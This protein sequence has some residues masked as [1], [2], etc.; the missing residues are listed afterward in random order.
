MT[1]KLVVIP[2]DPISAYEDKGTSSWLKDYYNPLSYFDEVF[3]L[4]PLEKQARQAYGL[5]IV[6]ITSN[7]HFKKVIREINPLAIR[8]YGGY[9]ASELAIYNRQKS[10]PIITS[11]HD[12]NPKNIFKCLI[13][14][15]HIICMSNVIKSIMQ[16][17]K[18]TDDRLS[19]LGNRVDFS[20][21]YKIKKDDQKIK[22]IRKSFP[23]GKII[24]HIGR[25]SEQKNLDN[26]INALQF[27]PEDYFLVFIGQGNNRPYKNQVNKI[28]KSKNVFWHEKIEN[29]DLVYWYNMADVFC[30][31][32]RWEGFGLVFIEAAACECK[33]I[34]SNIQPMNEFLT[35]DSCMNFLVN[36]FEDPKEIASAILRACKTSS[37]NR[38]TYN[39]IFEKFSKEMIDKREVEIY[40]SIINQNLSRNDSAEFFFW[41]LNKNL[42][43]LK[44]RLARIYGCK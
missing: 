1:K 20:K 42:Q 34:T 9:W 3:A 24:L 8:A 21:F 17:M 18:I 37:K 16:E 11:V 10:I 5:N 31:P 36:N 4:S 2:S 30:V 7:R 22:D 32:S 6:P 38:N 28:N 15:D 26:L 44:G 41:K 35:D 12:T 23:P 39:S 33:I 29:S 27:L 19:I 14:S 25:R 40:Q 13:F 43:K